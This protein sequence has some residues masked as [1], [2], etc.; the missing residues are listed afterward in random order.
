MNHGTAAPTQIRT[1]QAQLSGHRHYVQGVAWDPLGRYVISMAA[2]RTCRVHAVKLP[3]PGRKNAVAAQQH[4]PPPCSA[5]AKDLALVC[6]IAK[7]ALTPAAGGGR[8]QDP[9]RAEG[10]EGAAAAAPA[11]TGVEPPD[12]AGAPDA[13]AAAPPPPSSSVKKAAQSAAAAQQH[14]FQDES[15]STFFRRLSWSPDGALQLVVLGVGCCRALAAVWL[16]CLCG[17]RDEAREGGRMHA[18]VALRPAS[19]LP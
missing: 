18:V 10:E 16:G 17:C 7:R 6:A 19:K 9:Q 3:A 2:D 12:T 5:S 14:L 4:G 15:L 13:G 1:T 8:D 11:A